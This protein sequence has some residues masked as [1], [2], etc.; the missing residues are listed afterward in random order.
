MA[1]ANS[2][3]NGVTFVSFIRGYH[4]YKD[5]WDAKIYKILYCTIEENNL[6]NHNAVF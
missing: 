1:A 2:K 6:H 3:R 4:V 5:I